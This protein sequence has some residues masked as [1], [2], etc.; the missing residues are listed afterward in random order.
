MNI[1]GFHINTELN[2]LFPGGGSTDFW[3]NDDKTGTLVSRGPGGRQLRRIEAGG[4]TFFLKLSGRETLWRHLMMLLHGGLPKSGALREVQ[5]LRQLN[6][7]GFKTMEPVAWGRERLGLLTISGFVLVREVSGRELSELFDESDGFVRM[8]LMRE[9][10]Q[11][12]GRLHAKGFFQPV[13]LKDL[14]ATADGLVL[15][16][17]ETSKPWRSLF[18][19]RKCRAS[20]IRALRRMLRDGH[21]IG[22][23]SA[24]AFL[25]GYRE[26]LAA[27]RKVHARKLAALIFRDLRKTKRNPFSR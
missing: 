3:L 2:T 22:A 1:A 26:G 25:R 17:R 4:Q 7:E 5:M 14:I 11:L 6:A 15:I 19:Q 8:K 21:R 10:G 18:F 20:L 12:V 27:R 24:C 9:M 23:G 16:D 13:R